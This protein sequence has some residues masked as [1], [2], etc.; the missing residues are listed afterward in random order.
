MPSQDAA[1]PAT[2]DP[3]TRARILGAALPLRAPAGAVLFRP[4]DPCQGF[5]LLR[6]GRAR[7]DLIAE[8][9]HALLLYR[10][11]PG[12]ACAIT[13]SCLFAGEAYS[14]EGT[15]ETDCEGLLLPAPLFARLVEESAAF[16]TFVLAGFAA[17]LAALMGRIE[18]LSFRSVD[19][20][21]AA[22]LLDRAP[23]TVA[24]TQQE[25]A[26]DIGTAR[27]VVSRRLA[28]FAKAGLVHTERG[29]V[30]PLDLAGL[31]RIKDGTAVA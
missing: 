2:L 1:L 15:A 7:V 21:L 22:Y 23:G 5:V 25:I 4:G 13:T 10:V 19:A 9:G 17:R 28:A 3:A 26:S 31:T 12:Q 18:E 6:A 27:E 14:A 8:D 11:E 29:A 16:R 24:A 20:R 30:T